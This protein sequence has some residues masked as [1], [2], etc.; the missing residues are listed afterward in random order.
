MAKYAANPSQDHLNRALYICQ[1]LIGTQDYRLIYD[2]K[3]GGGLNA[4]VDS[5]WAADRTTRKSQTGFYVTLAGGP[6][7]WTSKAQKSVALSSTEAE[8]MALSDCSRQV[9]WIR[10]LMGELGFGFKKPTPINGD[11]Q[12]SIFFAHNPVTEKR[13]K[14]IDIRYH[15]VREKIEENV[16]AISFIEGVK[17]PADMFTKN[18]GHIKFSSCLK[19]LGLW[20]AEKPKD[21]E[22]EK[23][24]SSLVKA[25]HPENE[26]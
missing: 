25:I 10:A 24:T 26:K 9:V 14:H 3:T 23:Q 21:R 11:N 15:Y 18:L 4:Y 2:G 6:I 22:K 16:V 7:S 13:S 1:Y 20:F 19:E 12:G 5:D 8:Y 17:N